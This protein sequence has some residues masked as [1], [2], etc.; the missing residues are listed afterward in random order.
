MSTENGEAQFRH[1]PEE[2]DPTEDASILEAVRKKDWEA[3]GA[4][5]GVQDQ[6]LGRLTAG[7]PRM[8]HHLRETLDLIIRST[9]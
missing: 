8:P 1:G 7:W 2:T 9:R 4:L 5:L 3:L 6:E